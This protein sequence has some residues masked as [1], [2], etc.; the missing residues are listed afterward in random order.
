[1]KSIPARGCKSVKTA[2]TELDEYYGDDYSISHSTIATQKN[3]YTLSRP[4]LPPPSRFPLNEREDRSND[5][6]RKGGIPP[7]RDKRTNDNSNGINET[8]GGEEEKEKYDEEGLEEQ[9]SRILIPLLA[10]RAFHLPGYTW[11]QDWLQYIG[12][13]HPIFG[14]FCHHKLHPLTFKQRML[15]LVGSISCGLTVSNA[16][17]LYFL[18][19]V[20][21]VDGQFIAI[22][23][24]SNATI[25]DQLDL[26]QEIV[27]TNY[28][29]AL[30]TLGT[31]IHCMFDLSVW[32][33]AACSCCQ[34]GAILECCGG[35]KWIGTYIVT[36]TVLMTSA[37][38]LFIVMFRA[39]L[40]ESEA[41]ITELDSAGLFDDAIQLGTTQGW[42]SYDFM[43]T[44]GI[45]LALSLFF[46]YFIIG[47][48]LFSGILGCG[49][50][51]FLGGRPRE[52]LVEQKKIERARRKFEK[53]HRGKAQQQQ[54]HGRKNNNDEKKKQQQGQ[55]ERKTYMLG[56]R[57]SSGQSTLEDDFYSNSFRGREDFSSEFLGNHQRK[58][59][60]RKRGGQWHDVELG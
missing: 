9:R 23:V 39:S 19:T 7:V 18:T 17:Y 45:E 22:S 14:L 59:D 53:E 42:E 29:I 34:P 27:L 20:G 60:E 4:S 52:V 8:E 51:P 43:I 41:K 3:N 31:T 2:R 40:E 48:I 57:T 58:F 36:T 5:N 37:F 13:N 25:P 46:Y 35:F 44:L 47:T 30:W 56:K 1:M 50:L 11:C 26:N 10:N 28:Q 32:F 38:A 6:R 54:Q 55:D 16:I 21:G 15:V 24:N 12:N 33:V 49:R